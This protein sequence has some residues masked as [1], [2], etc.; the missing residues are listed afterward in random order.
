MIKKHLLPYNL[1]FFAEEGEPTIT[2]QAGLEDF[3]TGMDGG[4]TPAAEEEEIPE[5]GGEET[6]PEETPPAE[7]KPQA[8]N[9]QAYAFA[10]MRKQNAQLSQQAQQLTQLLTK[11][12]T[13]NGVQFADNNDLM[14]KLNDDA[15]TKIAQKQGIP[16]EYLQRMEVL[17]QHYQTTQAN[18]LKNSAFLGFQKVKDDFKLEEAELQAF[19]QELDTKGKNPFVQ[20]VDLTEL[21]TA[22]HFKDILAKE[23]KAA[24]EAALKK[25]NA[26]DQHSSTPSSSKGKPDS[27]KADKITTMEGIDEFLKGMK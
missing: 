16:K 26:A 15:L 6:P 25:S 4:T 8:D 1:Q 9:K 10:E 12:A 21:Y 18:E 23:T 3:L 5:E 27:G 13:A 14:S 19:A 11:L 20:A 7:T 17:E 24:V 22:W 2:D